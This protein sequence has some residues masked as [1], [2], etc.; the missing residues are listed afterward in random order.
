MHFPLGPQ[1]TSNLELFPAA[2]VVRITGPDL[3]LTLFGQEHPPTIAASGLVFVRS[4]PAHRSLALSYEGTLT[5][6]S[7]PPADPAEGARMASDSPTASQR[8]EGHLSAEE[9]LTDDS[10]ARGD[11]LVRPV[12][13]PVDHVI[14]A[15]APA[16]RSAKERPGHGRLEGNLVADPVFRVSSQ[17]QR[18]LA[19]FVVAQHY[20]DAQGELQT[21]YHKCVAFNSERKRLA[22]QVRDQAHQG[23]AIVVHGV[24]H[25][26]PIRTRDGSEKRERQLWAYGLKITPRPDR[27]PPS[28]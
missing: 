12:P 22:D 1:Q 14:D 26:V 13:I 27:L 8:R 21:I 5:L 7:T 15:P 3:Q 16:V 24:W 19:I 18:E 25:D 6:V 4:G 11:L 2:G 28:E 10:Q 9:G 20:T 23:D 17:Q